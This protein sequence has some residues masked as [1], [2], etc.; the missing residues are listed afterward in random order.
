[1][2]ALFVVATVMCALFT[3]V[4]TYMHTYMH[5][6]IH[7]YVHTYMTKLY[8]AGQ[9]YSMAPQQYSMAPQQYGMAPQQYGMAPQQYG[10]A[11]QQYG[12]PILGGCMPTTTSSAPNFATAVSIA[13]SIFPPHGV[14]LCVCVC[15]GVCEDVFG[16]TFC[17]KKTSFAFTCCLSAF[18]ASACCLS[19]PVLLPPSFPPPHSRQGHGGR[20]GRRSECHGT[21]RLAAFSF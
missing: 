14:C 17:V 20:N 11:S 10:M 7:T 15:W 19:L 21:P 4:H 8:R 9:Q 5:A 16:C 13:A 1:M 6:Y 18:L 2:H 12:M 3:Y